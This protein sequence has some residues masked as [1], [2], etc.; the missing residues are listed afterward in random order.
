MSKITQAAKDRCAAH[1]LQEQ[2]QQL[3]EQEQK[4]EYR[5]RNGGNDQS[6][7]ATAF[8]GDTAWGGHHTRLTL[9]LDGAD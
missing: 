4:A 1:T 6:D 3:R 9:P 2:L 7:I 5:R 8:D